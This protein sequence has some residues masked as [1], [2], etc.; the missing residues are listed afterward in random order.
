VAVSAFAVNIPLAMQITP[1][2]WPGGYWWHWLFFTVA[3]IMFV[4][5]MVIGAIYIERRAMGKMQSRLGPNRTGPFGLLQPVADAV[6]VLLKETS[7]PASRIKSSI[8]WRRWWPL[9]RW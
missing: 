1:A 2:D 5:V 9:R 8:S 6:K 3:I 4:L 7:S